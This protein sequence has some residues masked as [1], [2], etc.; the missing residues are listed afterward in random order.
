MGVTPSP[1]GIFQA[2][3]VADLWVDAVNGDDGDDG[4]TPATALRTIQKAAGL[5]GPG[6]TVHI[7]P[8]VYRESVRPANSGTATGGILYLAEGGPGTVK[9]RGSESSS[10]LTWT[11]LALDTIGLPP[12]VDPNN[13]YYADLSTWGLD[14]PPRFIVELDG[15]GEVLTRLPQ[16]REPDW[17]VVTPWKHHEY[18]WAADGG[19]DVAGCDPSTD[20]DPQNCDAPWRSNTQ[21]TDRTDDVG[22]VGIETGNLTTLGDLAGATLVAL[23]TVQGH[24]MCRSTVVDHNV[25]TGRVTVGQPCGGG[26]GWGSKYYLE[27]LPNLLD[28]PGE[29]WYDGNSGYLYLWPRTPGDPS[30]LNMEISKRDN[31]FSLDDRSYITLDGLTIELLNGKAI[32]LHNDSNEKAYYD[33]VRNVTLR[34]ANHGLWLWQVVRS[35]SPAENIIYGFTLEDSEISHMDTYAFHLRHWWENNAAADAYTRSGILNTTIRRNEMHHLGFRAEVG[36]ANG[37]DIYFA[38][39]LRFENNHVHDVAHNGI[40]FLKSVIQSP[41]K[42]DFQPQEIKTGEI[43][44]KDNFFERACQL[45]ADC[46]GLKFWGAPPESH[47]FR[48]LLVTGNIFRDIYGWSYVSE[49]RGRWW[50][51]GPASDVQGIGGFGLYLDYASGIHAYRNIAYNNSH[52]AYMF[53]G[54][55]QDGD[56]IYYNNLAA[57]SLHGF[58][59]WGE[60]SHGHV[61]TQVVNNIILNSE[62]YGISLSSSGSDYG[63]LTLDHNL[64]YQNGWRPYGEGGVWEA[65]NLEIV[66]WSSPNEYYQTLTEIQANTPWEVNGVEGDPQFWDYDPNDRDIFDGSWPDFHLTAESKNALDQGTTALPDSLAALLDKFEVTDFRLGEA[67]DIGRYEGGFTLLVNPSEQFVFPGGEAHYILSLHPP[68]F[69]H[70]VAL[71]VTNPSPYLTTT[72]SSPVLVPGAVETLTIANSHSGTILPSI[73]YTLP[74]SATGGGF[75]GTTSVRL[76]VGG[77]RLHVPILPKNSHIGSIKSLWITLHRATTKR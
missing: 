47:V 72:L 71:T 24:W 54:T 15:S 74:I 58:R 60:D 4:L 51:G 18:W 19:W 33:T 68:D 42:Y 55:W 32:D 49:K 13:I 14:G 63:N 59:L 28:T 76:S 75:S 43:L 8:G 9:I 73:T 50:S 44:I 10:S 17:Q 16:A 20:P 38:H 53:T 31:G 22:P 25:F 23:D 48:D 34:Y 35:D 36:N 11:Q 37:A 21:L 46:G 52:Y 69:P 62:G 77:A 41:R 40:Q 65:G 66:N 7:L 39:R 64:Y 1:Y 5:A 26:L 3:K 27:G 61:N 56:I 30:T 12:G 57:N 67:Y 70:P 6:T 29:W 2:A 45:T